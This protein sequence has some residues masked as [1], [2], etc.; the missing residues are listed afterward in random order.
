MSV[1]LG[2]QLSTID[3]FDNMLQ[4]LYGDDSAK[5]Y[6]YAVTLPLQHIA[7]DLVLVETHPVHLNYYV[8]TF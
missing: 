4:S 6:H 8:L 3:N 7:R 1:G 5:I 2:I